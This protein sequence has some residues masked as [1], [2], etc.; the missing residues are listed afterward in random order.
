VFINGIL[1]G[2]VYFTESFR[3]NIT[4]EEGAVA[5]LS[6]AKF[7]A[8]YDS[9]TRFEGAIHFTRDYADSLHQW[10]TDLYIQVTSDL[11][12]TSQPCPV[13]QEKSQLL[14]TVRAG[15]RLL[16]TCILRD[17]EE[18]L[19]YKV[20]DGEYIGYIPARNTIT[21]Q[22]NAD[23]AGINDMQLTQNIQPDET[24]QL[25]G[26]AY[27]RCGTI[28]SLEAVV[29]N[30][31]GLEMARVAKEGTALEALELPQLPADGYTVSVFAQMSQA[32][33]GEEGLAEG[34]V[35]VRLLEHPF[36]VGPMVRTDHL[37][38]MPATIPASEGWSV[39]NGTWYYYENGQPYTGW[40]WEDGVR[41]YQDYVVEFRRLLTLKSLSAQ[42]DGA[43]SVLM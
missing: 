20:E 39:E 19:F 3:S 11:E 13:G 17:G 30:A 21:Q 12:L 42:C 14:R 25:S 27:S 7:A 6:I 33:A 2:T 37:R 40:L 41:Y 5:R 18:Q 43:A 23:H 36:W 8:F 4:G 31:S 10:Q 32:Y 35:T 24:L 9:W 22:F 26:T 38:M 1:D 15:E 28:R 16:V 34:E 29:T